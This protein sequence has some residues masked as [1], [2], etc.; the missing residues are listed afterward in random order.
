MTVALVQASE[1][2]T[3]WKMAGDK[4]ISLLSAPLPAD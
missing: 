2:R 3:V 1:E 4:S